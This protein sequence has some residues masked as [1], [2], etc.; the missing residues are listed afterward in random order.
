M[1]SSRQQQQQQQQGVYYCSAFN[2]V[3]I[4]CRLVS[5]V[6]VQVNPD[7]FAGQSFYTKYTLI[8][9][10]RLKHNSTCMRVYMVASAKW[11]GL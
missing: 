11:T 1:G 5:L 6:T 10:G 2:K 3:H 9:R 4:A 8:L 7:V